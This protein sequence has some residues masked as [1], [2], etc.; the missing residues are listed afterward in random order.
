M[1]R[2]PGILWGPTGWRASAR[3]GEPIRYSLSMLCGVSA[4]IFRDRPGK[5]W[6]FSIEG[7]GARDRD[8]PFEWKANEH[9][10]YANAAA[11]AQACEKKLLEVLA[12]VRRE[13]RAAIQGKC[14]R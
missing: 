2:Q 13:L 4:I 8:D 14:A 11:A 7:D 12:Q 1:S 9:G 5:P 10:P 6:Y 3:G